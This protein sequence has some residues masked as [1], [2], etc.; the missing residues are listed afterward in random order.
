[1]MSHERVTFTDSSRLEPGAQPF[2]SRMK[3]FVQI[4]I[5]SW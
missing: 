5:G 1:M 2:Q 3:H 4:M